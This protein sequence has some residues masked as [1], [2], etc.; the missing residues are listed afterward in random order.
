M[1]PQSAQHAHLADAL[2]VKVRREALNE[3]DALAAV[4]LQSD[5][6]EARATGGADHRT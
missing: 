4:A 3:R 2:D 1:L 6:Q 5:G